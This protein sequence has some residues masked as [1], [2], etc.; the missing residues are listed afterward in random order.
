M[1]I[2]CPKRYGAYDVMCSNCPHCKQ[3]FLYQTCRSGMDHLACA[4]WLDDETY[5]PYCCTHYKLKKEEKNL[6]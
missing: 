5:E 1:E 3:G 2:K 6:L 4:G